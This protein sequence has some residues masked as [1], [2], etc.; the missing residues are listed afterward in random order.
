MEDLN[1]LETVPTVDAIVKEEPV[2]E[3][4][5]VER[6]IEQAPIGVPTPKPTPPAK[7]DKDSVFLYSSKNFVGIAKGCSKV[8]K[9]LA[10]QLLKNKNIRLATQEEI[11]I[12]INK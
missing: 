5:I 6:V 11:N 7:T 8:D 1:K 9:D 2:V 10:E 12:Q 3:P 4:V